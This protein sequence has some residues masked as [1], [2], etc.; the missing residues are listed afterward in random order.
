MRCAQGR[1]SAPIIHSHPRILPISP[2]PSKIFAARRIPAAGQGHPRGRHAWLRT[3]RSATAAES[4]R[5]N[6]PFNAYPPAILSPRGSP[7]RTTL[8]PLPRLPGA[9]GGRADG[10]G[11]AKN[12]LPPQKKE[13]PKS[14]PSCIFNS[15]VARVR[16]GTDSDLA[17]SL[18]TTGKWARTGE[19]WDAE[20]GTYR[21]RYAFNAYLYPEQHNRCC[22]SYI[23][24]IFSLRKRKTGARHERSQS[25]GAELGSDGGGHGRWPIHTGEPPP[26]PGVANLASP[27]GRKNVP[28]AVLFL[29]LCWMFLGFFGDC[30]RRRPKK[31]GS[32][33]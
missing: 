31:C 7:L 19:D 5:R 22:S 17:E 9:P 8:T 18:G 2:D 16:Q 32:A 15:G 3:G 33:A 14:P 23:Y 24:R 28:S 11:R 1:K 25:G 27:S 21:L 20:F 10:G 12:R 13:K 4:V 26:R 6:K 29:I 30:R